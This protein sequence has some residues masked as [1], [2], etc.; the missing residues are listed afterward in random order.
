MKTSRLFVFSIC[1][2]LALS[3]LSATAADKAAERSNR[4]DSILRQFGRG[5]SNVATGVLEVP[6]N[7]VQVNQEDGPYAALTYGVLR[8]TFRCL[9]RE[10]VGV[11]EVCTFPAGFK[12]IVKPEFGGAPAVLQD[13]FDVDLRESAIAYPEWKVCPLER[14]VVK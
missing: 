4:I 3:A 14:T 1:G 10:S 13:T 11:F 6:G 2:F 8:G 5:I 9:V 12:T 7:V